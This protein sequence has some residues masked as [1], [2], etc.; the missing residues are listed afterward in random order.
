VQRKC[1][2]RQAREWCAFDDFAPDLAN[3]R[4]S[5]FTRAA[6]FMYRN[7]RRQTLL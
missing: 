4:A 2:T 6:T 7:P 1:Q 3:S 5:R